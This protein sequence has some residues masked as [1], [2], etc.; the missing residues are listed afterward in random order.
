M[1]KFTLL[2]ALVLIISALN[3]QQMRKELSSKFS[4]ANVMQ[5]A[6]Q[7][8]REQM[9]QKRTLN[10]TKNGQVMPSIQSPGDVMFFDDFES[11]SYE[12][13][14]TGWLAVTN[15][16][17]SD[18]WMSYWQTFDDYDWNYVLGVFPGNGTQSVGIMWRDPGEGNHADWLITPAI[19]LT[20]GVAYK[21]SF[22]V[23][24]MGYNDAVQKLALRIGTS[25]SVAAMETTP[26]WHSEADIYPGQTVSVLYT[27]ATTGSYY[28]GFYDYSDEDAFFTSLDDVKVIEAEANVLELSQVPY[29]TMVPTTQLLPPVRGT[30]ANAGSAT[31][32]NVTMTA[33]LNGTLAGT[34]TPVSSLTSGATADLVVTSTT[35]NPAM[36]SNTVIA[37]VTSTQGATA[38]N[39]TSFAGTT[40]TYALDAAYDTSNGVGSNTGTISFGNV[41][42]IT[43]ATSITGASIGFGYDASPLNYTIALYSMTGDLTVHSTPLFT[44]SATRNALGFT[45]VTL[46]TTV[47]TPGKYFLCVNQLDANNIGIMFDANPNKLFYMLVGNSLSPISG[48][49]FGAVGIRMILG[50]QL[51]NDAAIMAITAPV[52]GQ[53]LSATEPVTATIK[54]NGSNPIT[55]VQMILTVDGTLVATETY[56]GNLASGATANYTFSATADC[57]DAGTHTIKVE[58]N[59]TGDENLTNNSMTVTITNTICAEIS[60]PYFENFDASTDLPPC[61]STIDADGDG[62]TWFIEPSQHLSGYPSYDAYSLENFAT[63]Q[64]WIDNVAIQPDNYLV[65]PKF[66]IPANGATLKYMIG[67]SY[68]GDGDNEHYEVLVS[69]TG[70]NISDFTDVLLEETLTTMNWVARTISLNAYAGQSIYIAFRHFNCYDVELLKLDDFGIITSDGVTD[71]QAG[72]ITVYPN[73]VS[74]TFV[75]KNA[76]GSQAKIYDVSGKMI[77]TAPVTTDNQTVDI[78]NVSAGIYFLELQSSTS[79][80]TVKLIKK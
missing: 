18:E 20:G 76:A 39:T 42:E 77:Y 3:A 25:Q 19:S 78:S 73:P 30:V 75:I 8:S 24:M 80:S 67:E 38:S 71:N 1:R 74:T 66:T 60:L 6:Q 13:V 52:S 54:N 31:Q 79:K 29:Y 11:Y 63:S 69:T 15:N 70:T 23:A 37:T 68:N 33:T 35:T 16:P 49:G 53:S 50:E 47:L 5:S 46:P 4:K 10:F 56:S 45:T 2:M 21:I 40:D 14:P 36:G 44:Q 9:H 27:P 59:M 48:Q 26:L 55:S 72:N 61:W 12:V 32:T 41:F 22:Y 28:L 43:S 58:V 62:N 64:S 57:S 7:M 65:T 51:D 17:N 34:S